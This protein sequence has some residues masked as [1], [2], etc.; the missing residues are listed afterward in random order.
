MQNEIIKRHWR[1]IFP[2]IVMIIIFWFSSASSGSSTAMSSPIA[3]FL[4][5]SHSLVRKLA[6][7]IAFGALGASWYYYLRSLNIFTPGFTTFGSF[8]FVLIFAV[9]DEYHQSFVPGRTGQVSDVLL[10][11]TAGI[12]GIAILATI[13]FV[14]APKSSK[15]ARRKQVDRLWQDNS[16]L[17]KNFRKKRKK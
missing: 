12:A 14:A 10:D 17:I 16:K 1:I 6:H 2:I 8:L 15:A 4:G 11:A 7:F 3:D 9:L 5:M 13:L